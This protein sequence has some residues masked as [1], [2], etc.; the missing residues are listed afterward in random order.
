M[1]IYI[2]RERER[3]I[4]YFHFG[5]QNYFLKDIRRKKKI[6]PGEF[7]IHSIASDRDPIQISLRKKNTKI[8]Y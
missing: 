5:K 4:T 1:Y 2:Y 3:E 7:W 6:L 8:I